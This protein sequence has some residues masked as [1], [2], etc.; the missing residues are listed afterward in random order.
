MPKPISN[1]KRRGARPIHLWSHL[2]PEQQPDR[3]NPQVRGVDIYRVDR[4]TTL[5]RELTR[6]HKDLVAHIKQ[7]NGRDPDAVEQILITQCTRLRAQ[8]A[9]VERR[10]I[11]GEFVGK[12]ADESYLAWANAFRRYLVSLNYGEVQRLAM[13]KTEANLLRAYS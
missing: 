9:I 13:R 10:R 8:M 12:H 6:L 7:R 1:P 3:P 4:R 2:P 5:G 11:D